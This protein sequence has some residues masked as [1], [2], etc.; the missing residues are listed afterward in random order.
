M[1]TKCGTRRR[2]VDGCRCEKCKRAN[3][4]YARVLR[5]RHASRRSAGVVQLRD[6]PVSRSNGPVDGE[7]VAAVKEETAGLTQAEARTALVAAA[8]ALARV[9]DNPSAVNQHAAA[10][11]ELRATLEALHKGGDVR[12]SRLAAVRSMTRPSSATG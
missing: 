2:Y 6:T 7:T 11:K 8:L 1:A 12:R 4:E 9:L 3:R 5:Q 10:S